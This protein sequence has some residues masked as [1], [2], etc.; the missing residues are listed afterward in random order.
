MMIEIGVGQD[1]DLAVLAN[2]AEMG[3]K[4][5]DAFVP[6]MTRES[7]LETMSAL[8]TTKTYTD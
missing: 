2:G 7:Y 6:E 3:A 1:D 5:L 8:F 4:V